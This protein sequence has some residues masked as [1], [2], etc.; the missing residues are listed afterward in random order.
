MQSK[1]FQIYVINEQEEIDRVIGVL[2]ALPGVNTVVG[3]RETKIFA[4]QWSEPTEWDDIEKAI[5][6]LHYTPAVS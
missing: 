2:K 5:L 6:K 4:I 1:S 3:D